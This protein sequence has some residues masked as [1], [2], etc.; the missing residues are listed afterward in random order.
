MAIKG[1]M[2]KNRVPGVAAGAFIAAAVIAGGSGVTFLAQGGG[3]VNTVAV[4]EPQDEVKTQVVTETEIVTKVHDP[5]SSDAS[6]A[7]SNTGTAEGADSDHKE[8][9]EHDSAQ[10]PTAPTDPTLTITGN[11]D[12]PVSALDAVAGPARPGTV[13]VIENGETLSSISQDSG[14]PVG[15][16]IDR[17]KLVDPDLI[18]AGTPLAIP[19]EQELAAAI[20]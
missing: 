12:T 13:H 2:P 18:Y 11:G 14:V 5:S 16:I 17:N 8:P 6:D 1:A 9:R 20:Q 4:V 7:D 19:T 15:L 3:D 10:E